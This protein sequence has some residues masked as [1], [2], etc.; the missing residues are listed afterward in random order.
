[1]LF[2]EKLTEFSV[3]YFPFSVLR[4]PVVKYIYSRKLNI[5]PSSN[6][7]SRQITMQEEFKLLVCCYLL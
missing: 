3:L 5:L 4:V 7:A 2:I 1:M 6:Q